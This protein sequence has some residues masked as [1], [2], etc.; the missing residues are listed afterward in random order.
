M[1]ILNFCNDSRQNKQK[2]NASRHHIET[3]DMF[4]CFEMK[5]IIENE[6]PVQVTVD[7]RQYQINFHNAHFGSPA[8][9]PYMA[10]LKNETYTAPIY[11]DV[12]EICEE[13]GKM[14]RNW[15][16]DECIAKI[17]I[18][19]KCQI[20]HL[21]DMTEQQLQDARES[22]SDPGGYFIIK[23]KERVLVSQLRMAYNSPIIVKN[24]LEIR[25]CNHVNIHTTLLKIEWDGTDLWLHTSFLREKIN[26]AYLFIVLQG[27]P[28]LYYTTKLHK[29]VLRRIAWINKDL[30]RDQVVE[31]VAHLLKS[32]T[33]DVEAAE[34][35]LAH[36]IFPHLGSRFGNDFKLRTICFLIDELLNAQQPD[37]PNRDRLERDH[38]MNKR[39][40][41]AGILCAELFRQMFKKYCS[42]LLSEF[43]KKVINPNIR[44]FISKMT[45]IER[46]FVNCFLNPSWGAQ[47]NGY[48]RI[49]VSQIL[50]NTNFVS[51]LSHLQRVSVPITKDTK[52]TQMRQLH[53]SQMHYICGCESPEGSIGLVLNLTQNC[54][55][56]PKVPTNNFV[57]F[58]AQLIRDTGTGTFC[59]LNGVE[60]GETGDAQALYERV[61]QL[62]REGTIPWFVSAVNIDHLFHIWTDEGRFLVEMAP[63]EWIDPSE[64]LKF[65]VKFAPATL[66]GT[67]ASVIP[68]INHS[69]APRGCYGSNMIK[70]AIGHVFDNFKFRTETN[71]Y[72]LHYPQKMLVQTEGYQFAGLDQMPFGANV[73]VAILSQ[74][75]FNLEDAC[76]LH[77]GA[78]DR[79]L[80]VS[81]VLMT[82]CEEESSVEIKIGMPP[83]HVLAANVRYDIGANGLPR[84]GQIVA[85]GDVLIGKW[86]QESGKKEIDASV[87]ATSNVVV[88]QVFD[89]RGEFDQRIVKVVVR[90]LQIPQI[91][92]KFSS[93]ISQKGV[94]GMIYSTED[95][96][97][98]EDGTVPDI[99]I[100]P[101]CIPS[102]MTIGQLLEMVLGTEAARRGHFYDGTAFRG[103]VDVP[104]VGEQV[105]YSGF[106]GEK[107][108]C[109]VFVGIAHYMRLK[110]LVEDKYH[111]RNTGPITKLTRQPPEGR[112]RKGGQKCGE[113]EQ[114]AIL[115]A[116]ATQMLLERLFYFSDFFSD[117]VC[118]K[119]GEL[120]SSPCCKSCNYNAVKVNMPY[121]FKLMKQ[122]LAV[123]NLKLDLQVSLWM[124]Q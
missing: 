85:S 1:F 97:F 41:P 61:R 2:M 12:E 10:R 59:L 20:C 117:H 44:L 79:G 14:V 25:F 7:S 22:V 121:I 82:F 106:T 47:Q 70:Q 87:M 93:L 4:T 60:I 115:V 6:M 69:P 102:R 15:Y 103:D 66:F 89:I 74:T 45:I 33:G 63:G 120:S 84:V 17:P 43:C 77:K 40:E 68:F 75:G 71:L 23:G 113:M 116:G 21:R 48:T 110:H 122:E 86:I 90:E 31:S 91:G 73:V 94:V 112:R 72:Q 30:T 109:T 62:R 37:A 98:M 81:S 118:E 27:A 28:K 119:C 13:N 35:V 99:I 56:S 80:F 76:I 32:F 51:V 39:V 55:V 95:M 42:L 19:L 92:D 58:F 54:R 83:P 111:A 57:H 9:L 52:N 36:E 65:D 46:K 67:S 24:T 88:S 107:F 11:V 123:M 78:I 16:Y 53:T 8:I 124:C 3:F 64:K 105:M 29:Q 18:P 104:D 108:A 26:L 100:N 96:P 49:G 50:S 5:N 34:K 38:L 114:E 101:H